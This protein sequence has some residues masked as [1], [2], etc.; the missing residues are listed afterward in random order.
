MTGFLPPGPRTRGV[1]AAARGAA[2]YLPGYLQA[3]ARNY[4]DVA[5]IAIGPMRV[6][7]L[8]S[9]ELAKD[10]LVDHDDRFEKGRGEQRFTRRLLEEGVLASEGEFHARQHRLLYPVTHGESLLRYADE[11]VAGA[12]RMESGWRNGGEVDAFE[13]LAR[14]TTD[15]M[16]EVM[17][18][19]GIAEPAGRELS[20]ALTDA[21][22]ALESLPIPFLSVAERLPLPANRRFQEAEDRLDALMNPMIAR[23]R[24]AGPD[25]G[26]MVADLAR[27]RHP[28]GAGMDDAQVN[29]ETLSIFRGHRTA[30]TGLCWMWYLLSRHPAV[31]GAVLREIDAIVGDR[32]PTSADYPEL[33]LCRR[34]FDEAQRLFPGAWMLSRRAV[35]EHEFGGYPLPVGATVITSSYVIQRDPRFHPEPRRFDPDRFLPDRRAGWHPFAYF[36]FGGGSKMCLGDEFA[37]FEAVLLLAAIGRRWRLRP[38]PG[39]PIRPAPKATF[40]PR[41]GMWFVLE[42]R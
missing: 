40:K 7:L 25:E 11:V 29:S 39:R 1:A 13:L 38:V 24:S 37:P 14:T 23:S 8:S 2:G 22:D 10:L 36:P 33:R 31:E 35:E 17:F 5:C 3:V 42:R 16:I 15:I 30:G 18:G 26:G 20:A 12:D 19:I 4:G 32:D 21:I 9:P 34:V 27:A 28:D 6:Y 41:G